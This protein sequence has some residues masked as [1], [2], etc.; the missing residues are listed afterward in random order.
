MS[1]KDQHNDARD[2][3]ASV[4]DNDN[5]ARRQCDDV[6]ESGHDA[7]DSDVVDSDGRSNGSASLSGSENQAELRDRAHQHAI[8]DQIL[9][10]NVN[11]RVVVNQR[12]HRD[13]DGQRND[14]QERHQQLRIPARRP[15]YFSTNSL[16]LIACVVIL[17]LEMCKNSG[18]IA[19]KTEQTMKEIS[20][21][22]TETLR[23]DLGNI[24]KEEVA[25]YQ[26]RTMDAMQKLKES[27]EKEIMAY[28][29][30]TIGVMEEL[31]RSLC[32]LEKSTVDTTKEVAAQLLSTTEAI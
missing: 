18:D 14:E 6:S 20:S 24:I 22:I 16:I 13:V 29:L 28:Q 11:H 30:S 31:N 19:A 26:L 12:G 10:Q 7:H 25:T 1:S 21:S 3:R 5:S 17:A 9:Y 2:R 15:G 32:T 27:L 23:K 4:D 8:D